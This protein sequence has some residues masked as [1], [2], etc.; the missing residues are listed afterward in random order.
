MDSNFHVKLDEYTKA[1]DNGNATNVILSELAI[2]LVKDRD[3]FIEVLRGAGL[4][5]E[6]GDTDLKLIETFV[7]NA[8]D[9]NKLLLGASF[10]IN[11]RNQTSNF[12]GES[13]VSDISVKN[14][15]KNLDEFFNGSEEEKSN[16]LPLLAPL[17]KGGC[18]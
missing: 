4:S 9:N 12:D 8:N 17:I 13:E 11:H 3:N 15:Y 10:L 16:F 2:S 18:W 6:D 7:N 14:T 1:R 5:V